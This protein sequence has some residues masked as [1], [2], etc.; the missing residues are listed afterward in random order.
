MRYRKIE[1]TGFEVSELCLGTW[2]LGGGND[3]TGVSYKDAME[4]IECM[5]DNGV[6]FID[7]A[8]TYGLG[9]AERRLGEALNC[10]RSRKAEPIKS[11]CRPNSAPTGRTR[12]ANCL[13][14]SRST[15]GGKRSSMK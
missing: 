9:E 4:A 7:T 12:K 11:S 15:T 6:N 3:W 14:T 8:P 10:V 13:V 2:P 1:R 5:L